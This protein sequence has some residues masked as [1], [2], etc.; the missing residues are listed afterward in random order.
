MRM[1]CGEWMMV[2]G[3]R[4]KMMMMCGGEVETEGE[5]RT[6]NKQGQFTTQHI[7]EREY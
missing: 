2:W 7:Q 5:R 3:G 4:A 6:E 1:C